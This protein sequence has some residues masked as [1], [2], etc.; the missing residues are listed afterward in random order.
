MSVEL[1]QIPDENTPFVNGKREYIDTISGLN[2]TELEDYLN[3]PIAEHYNFNI[4]KLG[5]SIVYISNSGNMELTNM[6]RYY[7]L[8]EAFLQKAGVQLP[9]VEIRDFK[10]LK[11][12]PQSYEIKYQKQ[13]LIDHQVQ[14]AA[15]IFCNTPLWLRAVTSIGF[16]TYRI[17]TQFSNVNSLFKALSGA[18]KYLES[19]KYRKPLIDL[20]VNALEY[21][22]NWKYFNPESEFCYKSAVIPGKVLYSS[23][24]G[25][26]TVQDAF[27][28]MNCLDAAL[29][30]GSFEGNHYYRIV[31]YGNI[32]AVSSQ[33]RKIYA[34]SIRAF[35]SKYKC[36]IRTAY[37]FNAPLFVQVYIKIFAKREKF[38]ILFVKSFE[39]A[40]E[41]ILNAENMSQSG[42]DRQFMISQSDID[43]TNSFFAKLLWDDTQVEPK[44]SIELVKDTQL[45]SPENPLYQLNDMMNVV[46]NEVNDLRY[47]QARQLSE[48]KTIF[49]ALPIGVIVSDTHSGGV[50]FI[51]PHGLLMLGMASS[52]QFSQGV[53]SFFEKV[54]EPETPHDMLLKPVSGHAYLV[55]MRE[56]DILFENRQCRLIILTQP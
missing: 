40:I 11:G 54:I 9:Y 29:N 38:P 43:E 21:N 3:F 23:I 50:Q 25:R 4:R 52:R 7:E 32:G 13:Y 14:K 24:Q 42:K 47:V 36:T 19:F 53:Q 10:K 20:N 1:S 16:K 39:Q 56:E 30:D 48:L 35:N 45:I 33:V 44:K 8:V 31:D 41:A 46:R 27:G 37:I 28:A 12:R 22:S 15:I 6:R 51:N 26:P 55:H 34:D 18:E 2:V 5:D 49:G 17:A